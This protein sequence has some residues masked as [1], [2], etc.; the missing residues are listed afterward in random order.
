MILAAALSMATLT[1]EASTLK[2]RGL[3]VIEQIRREYYLPKSK[4]YCDSITPEGKK[5]G[6][7]FN[8]GAGVMLS[9]LNAAAKADP[10]YKPW[11]REYAD[12]TRVYWNPKGP[13]PGYDVLPGPKPVDRY[14]D[15]NEWMVLALVETYEILGDTKYLDWAQQALDY[16]LSGWD[17]KLGGGIYWHE[18][19][20]ES[21]NT[22]SNAP[23]AAACFAVAKYRDR[24]KYE[25]WGG[26]IL[27]WVTDKLC[28][29]SDGLF[30][31]NI[32]LDGHIGNT[33]WSYNTG[34]VFRASA[35]WETMWVRDGGRPL[36]MRLSV[37][38]PVA[39]WF[40]L[41][42]GAVKDEGRFAHLLVEGLWAYAGNSERDE[43]RKKILAAY[44]YLHDKV[45]DADGR[46]GGR[47][48]KLP[49][50]QR[51]KFEMIDQAAAARGYLYAYLHVATR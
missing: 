4:L 30:W 43:L 5:S 7:S 41:T 12:A 47:W 33:K 44:D 48:D 45:R 49:D 42:K 18:P 32:R 38:G 15:D 16:V 10:K 19:K 39:H 8:W 6:P 25:D 36:D 11:L 31:D 24:D 35:M 22:C 17:D 29:P 26:K 40:D 13:V 28:D 21:K 27:R 23:A 9:A 46:Y 14:Y 3:E 50:P 2:E 51:K 34:L 20:K 1:L 37:N